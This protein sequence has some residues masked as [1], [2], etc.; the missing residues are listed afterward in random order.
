MRTTLNLDNDVYEAVRFLAE[1][2]SQSVGKVV[3]D[4]IKRGMQVPL[5]TRVEAGFHVVDLPSDTSPATT[6]DVKRIESESE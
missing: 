3:S 1:S 2:R 6:E 5:R 4:L